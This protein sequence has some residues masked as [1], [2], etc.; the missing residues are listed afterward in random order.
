[1]ATNPYFKYFTHPGEQKLVE[2]RIL[3]HI[4]IHGYTVK[5]LPRTIVNQDFLLNEDPLSTFD[6]AVELE[7]YI[8]DFQA[9]GG[10]GD[11][12]SK[13][14]LEIRDQIT[15]VI[16]RRRWEQVRAP[17]LI[18]ENGFTYQTEEANTN[19]WGNSVAYEMEE[20]DGSQYQIQSMRP[21]EGDLIFF[22]LNKKLFE[23]KFVEHEAV[24]Y[25]HGKLYTYEITCELYERDNRLNTGDDM[26]DSIEERFSLDL[27][28]N[29]LV[30]EDGDPMIH[31]DGSSMIYEFRLADKIK[32][33]NNEGI[34]IEASKYVDFSERNPLEYIY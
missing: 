34:K 6:L 4:K 18:M 22:P 7:V 15:F 20:G 27:L 31:E 29:R 10:D 13:F 8:K 11:F 30:T 17:K 19:L 9:F 14:M 1:M 5:Y 28:L 25:E 21:L 2:D 26:I 16:S 32:A 33:A 12:L 3:E 24:F 23:I